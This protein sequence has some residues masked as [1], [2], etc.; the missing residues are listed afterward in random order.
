MRK[1]MGIFMTVALAA[2]VLTACTQADSGSSSAGTGSNSGSAAS[3]SGTITASGDHSAD[4]AGQNDGTSGDTSL[5]GAGTAANGTAGNGE[6]V[7]GISGT[8]G[9]DFEGGVSVEDDGT[10][11]EENPAVEENLSDEEL[12]ALEEENGQNVED[13]GW[14][15]TYQNENDEILTVSVSDAQTITFSFADAG[16]SGSATLNDSPNQA[17]YQGD[18]YH[19]LVFDYSGTDIKVSV[20]SQEDYDASE[21]PLNGVYVRQ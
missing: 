5:A 6:E 17:T 16:I 1:R 13:E 20:L 9:E 7:S 18:D 12:D 2:V 3:G 14:A 11:G 21:S 15:G 19:V 4:G 10:E 8:E